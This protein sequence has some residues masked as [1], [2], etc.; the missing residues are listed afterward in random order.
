MAI[1][2][3]QEYKLAFCKIGDTAWTAL[4]GEGKLWDLRN[5]ASP[6][7][8]LIISHWPPLLHPTIRDHHWLRQALHPDRYLVESSGELLMVVRYYNHNVDDDGN[9]QPKIITQDSSRP[10]KTIIFDVYKLDFVNMDWLLLP[11]LG[12]DRALFIGLNDSISVSPVDFPG[13]A[14][15]CIYFTCPNAELL[16][17]THDLGVFNFE[18]NNIT[19]IYH[20]DLDIQLPS[21]WIVPAAQQ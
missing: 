5:P 8:T 9:Y 20:Y 18:D 17:D 16:E 11:S 2:G 1:Q 7:N 4:K 6:K 21:L 14:M 10:K 15:N 13:L 12:P 3:Y 19:P